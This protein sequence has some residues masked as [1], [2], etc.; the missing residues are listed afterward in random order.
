VLGIGIVFDDESVDDDDDNDDDDDDD[1]D[2]IHRKREGQLDS[3]FTISDIPFSLENWT[4]TWQMLAMFAPTYTQ[5]LLYKLGYIGQEDW[6]LRS[7][8]P[9]CKEA[10]AAPRTSL[11]VG[12]FG[13][14]GRAQEGVKRFILGLSSA[15]Q[16]DE[17]EDEEKGG[18]G[19]RSGVG[20]NATSSSMLSS[21]SSHD[22]S[23]NAYLIGARAL[24]RPLVEQKATPSSPAYLV[25]TAVPQN[26]DLVDAWTSRYGASCDAFLFIFSNEDDFRSCVLASTHMDRGVPRLFAFYDCTR[27]VAAAAGEK[28]EHNQLLA[29]ASKCLKEEEGYTVPLHFLS[30]TKKIEKSLVELSSR[31]APGLPPRNGFPWPLL[32]CGGGVVVIVALTYNFWGRKK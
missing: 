4:K 23:S 10:A 12:V 18:G 6:G 1:D 19:R 2:N 5:R 27:E 26:K 11:Q 14:G 16:L 22:Q 7:V 17:D 3:I 15:E 13:F 24:R 28:E 20:G 9:R 29:L 32:L 31:P 21:L 8:P 25:A 30:E